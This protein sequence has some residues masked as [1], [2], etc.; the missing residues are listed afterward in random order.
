MRCA[1]EET[2]GGGGDKQKCGGEKDAAELQGAGDEE[3]EQAELQQAQALDGDALGGGEGGMEG[4]Q[5]PGFPEAAEAGEDNEGG[6][7]SEGGVVPCGGEDVSEQEVFHLMVVEALLFEEQDAE[8]QGGGGEDA[9]D[10][11]GREFVLFEALPE[12]EG[13]GEGEE[14]DAGGGGE[15][16]G[17][18][19]G[20][21]QQGAV[22]EGVADIGEALPEDE[23]A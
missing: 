20:G 2:R 7:A 12:K 16:E 6:G 3:G 19:D 11:F 4:H 17:Q 8:G 18:G 15:A 21:A 10:G 5:H 14:G 1:A 23:A 22:A 9:Q 13:E